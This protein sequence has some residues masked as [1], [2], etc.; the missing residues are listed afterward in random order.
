VEGRVDPHS[1]SRG[2]VLPVS[3]RGAP[4]LAL[5]QPGP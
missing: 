5:R 4:I 3:V 1:I 2:H